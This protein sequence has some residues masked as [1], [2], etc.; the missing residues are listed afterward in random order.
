MIRLLAA[1][2]LLALSIGPAAAQ[3]RSGSLRTSSQP[4]LIKADQLTHH[5]DI[6]T[7]VAV[8]NVEITQEN[9]ILLA[10]T[11]TYNE[12]EDKVTASGN[13]SLTQVTGE[14]LFADYIELTGGMRDGYIENLRALLVDNSRLAANAARR[15][16]GN[17]K[18]MTRAVYSPCELCK[19]DPT[20]APLWQIKA[21][22]VVHDETTQ[23]I[24]YTDATMEMW[25]IPVAY[26]PTFSHPDPTVRQRTGVL[27]PKIGQSGDVGTIFGVPYY[28]ALGPTR[29]LTL[30]PTVYSS[31]GYVL[32]GEY[33]QLFAKG[34][35]DFKAS[36]GYLD[37]REG[38]VKTGS[39]NVQGHV[40]STGRFDLTDIWRSGFDIAR[41]SDR[42]YLKRYKFGDPEVLT[43]RGFAEG[44]DGRDYMVVNAYSFQGLRA[45]DNRSTSP[46]LAPYALYSFV[47]EPG[48]YGGRFSI[49]ASLMSLTRDVG[50]DSN[51]LAMTSGWTLPYTAPSG[52]IYTLSTLLYTDG[53]WTGD[54]NDPSRP[55][56][57][58][59][60]GFV[61]RFVPQMKLEW[62]YPW[63]RRDGGVRTL[64]E[65]IAAMVAS[66]VG[67]N[68]DR[69]PNEDSQAF[70]L[71]ETNLFAANRFGGFDRVSTGQRID[72]GL[73]FGLY[74]DAG[75]S[76]TLLLA[77][78]YAFQRDSA[79]VP[80]SGAD[81]TWSDYVGRLTVSPGPYLDLIYRFRLDEENLAF[82]R[83]EVG[84]SAGPSWLRVDSYYLQVDQ[85]PDLPLVGRRREIQVAVTAR[86]TEHWSAQV[87]LVRDLGA[88]D[89]KNRS[90]GVTFNYGDE[91]LQFAIDLSRRFTTDGT[92]APDTTAFVRLIFKNLG[93]V[94][95]RGLGF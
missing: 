62:R 75:R 21:V 50:A 91:C 23:D 32:S 65:P 76:T 1:V 46:L 16:D 74:D 26:M 61:G 33:R 18:E 22:K 84:L 45:L 67:G 2:I 77:Q 58:F 94:E 79:Y 6:G 12:R 44:F 3:I 36:G 4:V 38:G 17:R 48:R 59:N 78:S 70:E 86:L 37:Q 30:E 72:Y 47:G 34:M 39:Q 5:R 51:R 42:L 71:D 87:R 93:T 7:V 29:D 90:A 28:W 63:V 14:V 49:D 68:P 57:T 24:E 53:Y 11:V 27:A 13:V 69:I 31:D 85:R 80:G 25:G 54:V 9:Q 64:L 35:I 95:A 20:R 43:S 66:P 60:D 10:D 73:R 92:L 41:S 89:N 55:G 19:T 88:S 8:G 82:R 40:D 56:S 52:E 83:N 81:S 15:V